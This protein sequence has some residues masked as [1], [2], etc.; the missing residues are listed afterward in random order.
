M[1]KEFD[2]SLALVAFRNILRKNGH[3]EVA[4]CLDDAIG[5]AE[6]VAEHIRKIAESGADLP[7]KTETH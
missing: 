4:A 1:A 2:A 7:E 5:Q 3:G 6:K